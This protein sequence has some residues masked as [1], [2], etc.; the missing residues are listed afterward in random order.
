MLEYFVFI[1][2]GSIINIEFYLIYF[3]LFD[4]FSVNDSIISYLNM[5]NLDAKIVEKD[6]SLNAAIEEFKSLNQ[7]L[8][9]STLLN[10]QDL[11]II[12]FTRKIH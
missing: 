7:S 11:Y 6:S 3:I 12:E 10:F 8:Q 4:L 5:F 1:I 9:N 2:I